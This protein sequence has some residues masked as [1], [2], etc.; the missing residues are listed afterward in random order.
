[1]GGVEGV[2]EGGG[3]GV[4]E[5]GELR[6]DEVEKG[7]DAEIGVVLRK[8]S[9]VIGK[10]GAEIRRR[11]KGG[12]KGAEQV[13]VHAEDF[14]GELVRG[15]GLDGVGIVD[16]VT[17]EFLIEEEEAVLDGGGEGEIVIV[18]VA[19]GAKG[20]GAEVVGAAEEVA[21]GLCEICDAEP[22]GEGRGTGLPDGVEPAGARIG[23][24]GE[25]AVFID[26]AEAGDDDDGGGVL[27][28]MAEAGFDSGGLVEVVG[29]QDADEFGIVGKGNAAVQGCVGA[30]VFLGEEG[31]GGIG[32]GAGGFERMIGRAVVDDN[33]AGG[34][35][36]LRKEAAERIGD[37]ALV[38]EERDDDGGGGH[39]GSV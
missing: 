3:F 9:E 21:G 7:L 23:G 30:G 26:E 31:Y 20:V 35:A 29:I 34:R 28:E 27:V 39:R 10:T 17:Q 13:D 1:M 2:A 6:G 25:S 22:A 32:G 33:D 37:E 24:G 16:A 5:G 8:G 18:D 15:A 12:G 36:G 19:V 38:I 4:G 14:A 11:A